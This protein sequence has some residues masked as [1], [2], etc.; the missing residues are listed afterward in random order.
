MRGSIRRR[1]IIAFIG[2][3]ISPLLIV[4]IVL[5]WRSF[6]TQE[7]QAFTLQREVAR[8]VA[9]Q[10]QAFFAKLEDEMRFTSQVQ[11][12]Q[13]L[14]HEAQ[15]S[16]L[17]EL[18]SYQSAFE[19]LILLD[20]QGQ[21]HVRVSRSGFPAL[22][23]RAQ[24]D[25]FTIPQTTGQSYYSP[26]RFAET[27]MEP[28]MTMSVPLLNLRT[29]QAEGVLVA[30]VRI[31]EI[32]DLIA[33][34][35]VEP[36]QTVYI[37]DAQNRVVAHGN[38]S[39]VLRNTTFEVP[40]QSGVRP[41]LSNSSVVLAV[42]QVLL[43]KQQLNVVSEQTV[44]QALAPAIS[45]VL[46]TAI[47]IVAALAISSGL[48]FVVVRQIIQPIQTLA[49]TARMISAGELA[50]QVQVDS[51]DELGVLGEA[52]NSM[53]AQLQGFINGLEQQNTHLRATVSKYVEHMAEVARGNLVVRLAP[54][55]QDSDGRDPLLVLGQQLDEMT[56]SLQQMTRQISAAAKDL[57]SASMEV[58][59][60][61][62]Q[63]ASG[64]TEQSA[65]IVQ[66]STTIDQVRTIAR[67]TSGR[68]QGVAEQSRRTAEV[69]LAGQRAVAETI[70]GMGR[71]KSTVEEIAGTNRALFEQARAI[72]TI[73]AS[74][75][76]I[77]AQS[78]ILALNAA[79]EAARA[80]EAGRGF[81]VV[82]NEVRNL[83]EQSRAATVQVRDILSEIQRGMKAA[84][85]ASE[86]GTREV[87]LGTQLA[88]ESGLA[89]QR[90]AESV[91]ESAQAA[92]QISAATEQQLAGMEQIGVAMQ[93]IHQ[94]MNQSVASTQQSE[95][96]A[97]EL[98]RLAGQMHEMVE[99]YQ[100]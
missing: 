100:V 80:G 67:Q 87:D 79:V 77:A 96:A 71:I 17:S 37:M 39:V 99:Q 24:A 57:S 31:K 33:A 90:L 91:T 4:G 6:T 7:Q 46:I 18:L 73:I 65:A 55:G 19:E 25:E 22:G 59:A 51:H 43:G 14:D 35:R 64:A 49:T 2:L 98:D 85:L 26:I 78:N 8:R 95:R 74:V 48:G 45:L 54:D 70:A 53:T 40:A 41:G 42:A 58:L 29:G 47:L 94:V 9:A 36:G 50:L 92:V 84:M 93:N 38:R 10:V 72:G 12:L 34:I 15:Q 13:K 27:S 82:A 5:G 61:T 16:I 88:E 89:L 81:A 76:E 3:A 20:S 86:V 97:E 63:Q 56:A 11:G 83:A 52:F 62:T 68:A 44:S 60:A 21:E 66:T 23:S 75:N 32:W 69:S 28:L 30:E 1:L